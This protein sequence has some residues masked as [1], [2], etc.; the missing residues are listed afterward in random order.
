[1]PPDP[2][3]PS[4]GSSLANATREP[5]TAMIP[6]WKRSDGLTVAG[7]IVHGPGGSRTGYTPANVSLKP[8]VP[9]GIPA[10]THAGV[11]EPP[12]HSESTSHP[13]PARLP[14][15]HVAEIATALPRCPR[16]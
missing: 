12:P 1:M 5:A 7:R 9:S 11:H 6:G 14:P 16:S 3:P 8:L 13:A 15:T 4:I 10:A 2:S